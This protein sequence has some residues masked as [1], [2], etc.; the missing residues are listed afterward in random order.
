MIPILAAAII[1]HAAA[2]YGGPRGGTVVSGG[3]T[4]K[5]TIVGMGRKAPPP[6]PV[7]GSATAYFT[8]WGTYV[9]GGRAM[10]TMS[11]TIDKAQRVQRII[12]P[13]A[14]PDG[15]VID[16]GERI[17]KLAETLKIGDAVF[18]HYMMIY[19]RIYA[20]G[21]KLVKRLP[22]RPGAAPFTFIGKKI[23]RSGK[24]G[25]MTVT[26]NAGMIPCKFRVPEEVD[27]NGISRPSSKVA[28][29][30]KQFCRSDLLELEYKTEN[31]QFVL[32]G[33]K[34]ARKTGH[35]A[36]VKITGR[37][38]KGYKHMV[39]MIK[40]PRRTLTLVDP[41]A[42]IKLELANVA[43]PPPDP[44]VQTALKSLKPGDY[45]MFKYRRQRGVYWLDELYP[46]SRPEPT[47]PKSAKGK[48]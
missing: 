16:P 23:V 18:F 4:R 26:A 7:R 48:K 14:D 28:D 19:N 2:A 36:L 34:A 39:A 41:E 40:T 42:V 45:V 22:D 29:A 38:I 33:V 47:A 13:N 10:L 1:L 37:K 3:G 5:R 46:A 20:T 11:V 12:I 21:I 9:D 17:E 31:F 35:G 6:E 32:T 44:P 15:V 8:G 25:M 27:A 30:L 24:G 43:D